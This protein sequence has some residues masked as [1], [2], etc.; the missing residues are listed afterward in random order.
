MDD[1][2]NRAISFIVKGF[3]P[4]KIILFGSRV[5]GTAGKDSD[6]DLCILKSGLSH[7]RKAAQDLYRML[8]PTELPIDLLVETPETFSALKGN[9]FLIYRSIAQNG[10]VLYEKQ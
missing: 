7:K 9:Q 2:L 8:L 4:D 10:E 1:A 3:H 6:Y 5:S